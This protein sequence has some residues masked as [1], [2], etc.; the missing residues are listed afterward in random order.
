MLM[1]FAWL[2]HRNKNIFLYLKPECFCLF[3]K[4]LLTWISRLLWKQTLSWCFMRGWR[5]Q[6][7]EIFVYLNVDCLCLFSKLLLTWISMFFS[8]PTMSYISLQS[9][10]CLLCINVFRIG[11]LLFVW[12]LIASVYFINCHTH[13][14]QSFYGSNTIWAYNEVNAYCVMT[15]SK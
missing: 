12:I 6:N 8:V 4:L 2:R 7:K 10:G 13:E 11:I 14:I 1:T 9:C 15:S 3:D 5:H